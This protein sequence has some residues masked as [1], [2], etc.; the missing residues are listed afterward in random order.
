MELV[1]AKWVNPSVVIHLVDEYDDIAVASTS[2]YF[3]GNSVGGDT[4]AWDEYNYRQ[5]L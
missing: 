2:H 4:A 1:K 5:N 3:G